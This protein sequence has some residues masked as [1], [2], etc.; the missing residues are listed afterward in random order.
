MF[1]CGMEQ[2][3]RD[4]EL[5]VKLSDISYGITPSGHNRSLR[6]VAAL[7]FL[8]K[9][10]DKNLRKLN[11]FSICQST[12]RCTELIIIQII[13]KIHSKT[14]LNWDL[15]RFIV[16]LLIAGNSINDIDGDDDDEN[17]DA[18]DDN[19]GDNGGDDASDNHWKQ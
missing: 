13:E 3:F 7:I 2:L 1:T 15:F 12:L 14:N 8:L 4:V 18:D 5:P 19:N 11:I 16:S 10:T 17:D 9:I 6:A